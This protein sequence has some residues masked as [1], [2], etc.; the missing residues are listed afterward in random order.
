MNKNDWVDSITELRNK[1]KI[2]T[3]FEDNVQEKHRYSEFYDFIAHV[4]YDELFSEDSLSYAYN[5]DE[6]RIQ[7]LINVRQRILALRDNSNNIATLANNLFLLFDEIR[8]CCMKK[9]LNYT[10]LD[11]IGDEASNLVFCTLSLAIHGHDDLI[12]QLDIKQ[13][14]VLTV[15]IQQFVNDYF[16]G[17][18]IRITDFIDVIRIVALPDSETYAEDNYDY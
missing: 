9:K 6:E 11:G 15:L 5:D 12:Y 17:Q 7:G 4:E 13:R 14:V 18:T 10:I 16:D 8:I 3:N 1:V 2:F